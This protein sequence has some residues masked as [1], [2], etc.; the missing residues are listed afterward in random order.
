MAKN[1][2]MGQTILFKTYL[3]AG[4]WAKGREYYFMQDSDGTIYTAYVG[5]NGE[6]ELF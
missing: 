4:N 6:P 3:P 2:W 1:T 5:K